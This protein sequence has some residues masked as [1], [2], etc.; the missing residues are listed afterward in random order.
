M[1]HRKRI[2]HK[3]VYSVHK[4][5]ETDEPS[6]MTHVPLAQSIGIIKERRRRRVNTALNIITQI[7][8]QKIKSQELE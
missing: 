4:I 6:Y 5:D 7:V 2:T 8:E 3:K 1:G